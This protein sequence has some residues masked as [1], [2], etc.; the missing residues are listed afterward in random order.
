MNW[1]RRGDLSSLIGVFDHII[2]TTG[3]PA[4][5]SRAIGMLAPRGGLALVG[6]YPSEGLAIDPSAI[7]SAGR[8]IIGVV[9]GGIDPLRFIPRLIAYY[10]DGRLRLEK[11]VR[12][13]PFAQIAEAVA[14]SER[15]D[16]IKPVIVMPL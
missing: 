7:M 1:V 16:V 5:L 11:L 9:E 4:L 3:V 15:G 14:A 10:R 2:D 12:R 8:R 6:A 13:Y